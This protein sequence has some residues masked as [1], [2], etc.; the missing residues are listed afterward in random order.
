[1]QSIMLEQEEQR[2]QIIAGAHTKMIVIVI[3]EL[4]QAGRHVMMQIVE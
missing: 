1:M 4:H 3:I 2:F